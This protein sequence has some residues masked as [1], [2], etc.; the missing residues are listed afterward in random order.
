[1]RRQEMNVPPSRKAALH[2]VSGSGDVFNEKATKFFLRLASASAV[3]YT[4]AYAGEDGAVQI[5]TDSA[6]VY[7]PLADMV[8]LEKEKARLQKEREKTVS[9]IERVEKKLANEG[10]VSKAPA[11]VIEAEREKL[12]RYQDTLKSLD[13]ALAKL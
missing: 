6:T 2:I 7:I 10:F 4:D 9:E 12:R 5:V 13:E 8:D 11:Q 1:M 3:E